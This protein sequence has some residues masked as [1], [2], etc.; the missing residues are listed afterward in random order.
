MTKQDESLVYPTPLSPSPLSTPTPQ[1]STPRPPQRPPHCW[2]SQLT[3]YCVPPPPPPTL[4]PVPV[5]HKTGGLRD[6]VVDFNPFTSPAVGTGWTFT[7]FEAGA[8]I[9]TAGLA[10]T[11]LKKHPEDFR[12]IQ[13]RGMQRDSSW[14][15]AAKTYEQVFDWMHFDPPYCR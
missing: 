4:T 2:R 1:S 15:G 14:N 8:L 11:T 12:G 7:A 10:L 13:L 9:H 3:P 6:T 5:A